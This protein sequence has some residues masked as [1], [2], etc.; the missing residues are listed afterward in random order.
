MTLKAQDNQRRCKTQKLRK[1]SK[2]RMG[3][4][5]HLKL[6]TKKALRNKIKIEK[7]DPETL[8]SQYQFESLEVL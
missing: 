4:H 7:L 8:S 2:T 6:K 5:G 1:E 3:E